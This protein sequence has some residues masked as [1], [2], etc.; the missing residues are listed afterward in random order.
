MNVINQAKKY[1]YI[2]TP[3]LIIDNEMMTA[4]CL[5]SKK[6][7]DVRIITPGIPD[8]KLVFLLTRS[9]YRQLLEAGVRI[10]ELYAGLYP[11]QEL[12]L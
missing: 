7:I 1:I 2:T 4:L 9:Y 11:C 6:G 5:A 12:C 10:Y 3:Y 8:K